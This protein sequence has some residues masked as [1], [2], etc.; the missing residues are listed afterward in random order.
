MPKFEKLDNDGNPTGEFKVFND[1][2]ARR[3]RKIRN[4]KWREVD[5]D[6]PKESRANP[7]REDGGIDFP[8]KIFE[9]FAW[10]AK[11]NNVERLKAALLI[12]NKKSVQEKI[13]D[14]IK[15]LTT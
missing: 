11:E 9:Q 14:K 6:K 3:L 8:V 7:V 12:A 4:V 1:R 15:T 10:V 13:N 2:I 5:L